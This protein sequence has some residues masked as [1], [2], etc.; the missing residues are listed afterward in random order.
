[1]RNIFKFLLS[2]GSAFVIVLAGC[3]ATAMLLMTPLQDTFT[4]IVAGVAALAVIF[5]SA[6]FYRE[7]FEELFEATFPTEE[8]K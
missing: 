1:M 2:T 7:R 8:D 4:T 3:L 5:P 6:T